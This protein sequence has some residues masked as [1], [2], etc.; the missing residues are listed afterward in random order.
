[1]GA[2]HSL[3]LLPIRTFELAKSS[4]GRYYYNAPINRG[5]LKR[6]ELKTSQEKNK[7]NKSQVLISRC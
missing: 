4:F 6:V 2:S 3:L 7:K 1:M 5:Q